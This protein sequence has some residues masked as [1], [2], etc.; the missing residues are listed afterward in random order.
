[1]V[2]LRY[3]SIS[4]RLKKLTTE[5]LT[6]I[7]ESDTLCL[8]TY[9]YNADRKEYCS[10]AIAFNIDQLLE[11]VGVEPSQEL[12]LNLIKDHCRLQDIEFGTVKGIPGKFYKSNRKKEIKDLC[13][14]IVRKRT[15]S[16]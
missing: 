4:G 10:I 11:R 16:N 7:T 14:D 13:Q 8:D 1:M 3:E 6:R 12:V 5:Q 15:D 2:D 9:N